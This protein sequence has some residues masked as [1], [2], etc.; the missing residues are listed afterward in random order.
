MFAANSAGLS[1]F[2][3]WVTKTLL[4]LRIS[5]YEDAKILSLNPCISNPI[6]NIQVSFIFCIIFLYIV[7]LISIQLNTQ[8]PVKSALFT[9]QKKKKKKK[10]EV[11][12]K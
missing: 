4:F 9:I 2:I 5:G 12:K 7:S 3:P 11:K 1:Q 8:D 6:F 10:I